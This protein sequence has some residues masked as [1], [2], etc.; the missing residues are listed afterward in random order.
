MPFDSEMDDLW[1]IGIMET[2]SQLG[3]ECVRAD[4]MTSP[5]F[6]MSQVFEQIARA[7]IVLGEMSGRNPNVFYEIGFAHALGKPTILLA[8]SKEDLEVFD[9]QGFRHF[10]HNGKVK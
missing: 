10:L 5:G 4:G 9:T 2:L 6:V 8:K 1:E 3:Y 7:D